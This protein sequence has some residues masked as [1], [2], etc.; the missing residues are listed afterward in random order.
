MIYCIH[1]LR[2]E[3]LYEKKIKTFPFRLKEI[4]SFGQGFD[5]NPTKKKLNN[6]LYDDKNILFPG[7]ENGF[8]LSVYIFWHQN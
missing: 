2:T 5:K 8:F 3:K 7:M 6:S 1:P 4:C